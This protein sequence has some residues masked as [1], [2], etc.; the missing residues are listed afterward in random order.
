MLT[1]NLLYKR[2]HFIISFL[3]YLLGTN[4]TTGL[5]EKFIFTKN[6]LYKRVHFII[7]FLYYLLG[8]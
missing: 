7:S 4:T 6:L 2:V 5:I 8:L 3:Y 1:R